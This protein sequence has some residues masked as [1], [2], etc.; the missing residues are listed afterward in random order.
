M[1]SRI[2]MLWQTVQIRLIRRPRCW[3]NEVEHLSLH[4]S[5]GVAYSMRQS[6]VL[7]KD[8]TQPWDIRNTP[9]SSFLGRSVATVCPIHFDTGTIKRIL[10]Q[11]LIS[12]YLR[13]M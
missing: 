11:P 1:P 2:Q 9:G 10:V 13:V 5:D 4:E 6:T 8:K 3:R 12:Y 7:L